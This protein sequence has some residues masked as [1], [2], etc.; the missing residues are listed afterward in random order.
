MLLKTTI[1][2]FVKLSLAVILMMS[3][4]AQAVAQSRG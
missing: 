4:Q 2:F 1:R 3:M